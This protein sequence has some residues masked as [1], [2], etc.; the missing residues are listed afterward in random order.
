MD[1]CI[2]RRLGEPLDGGCNTTLYILKATGSIGSHN[3]RIKGVHQ[4]PEIHLKLNFH[5]PLCTWTAQ[6][7]E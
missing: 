2:H 6:Q 4:I 3:V 5:S 7:D 1:G